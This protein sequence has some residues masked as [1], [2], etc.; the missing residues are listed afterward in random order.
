MAPSL[1]CMAK[2]NPAGNLDV[3]ILIPRCAPAKRSKR[4]ASHTNFG[5]S[6]R[7]APGPDDGTQTLMFLIQRLNRSTVDVFLSLAF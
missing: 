5:R 2:T 4:S 3:D 7:T 6:L 1:L